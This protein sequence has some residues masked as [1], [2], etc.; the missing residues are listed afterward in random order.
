MQQ[1]QTCFTGKIYGC[2]CLQVLKLSLFDVFYRSVNKS[3]SYVCQ[4]RFYKQEPLQ[5]NGSLQSH[6]NIGNLSKV[7]VIAS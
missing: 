7:K 3:L 1:K 4:T 6:D 5:D 2:S